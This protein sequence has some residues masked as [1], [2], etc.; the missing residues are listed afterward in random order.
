MTSQEFLAIV[1]PSS[2]YYCACE[3]STS[4]KTH[5]FVETTDEVYNAAMSFSHLGYES[6]YALASF[7]EQGKRTA[8]NT[9]KMRSLFVDIDCG[10]GKDYDN[11]QAAAAAL[12]S[13]LSETTLDSLGTPYILSSG[14]GLHVYWPFQEDLDIDVWKP[15]A[16]N[17]KRLAKL[18]NFNI[19]FGVTADAARIL[20]VPDTNNY[21]KD[22]PRLVK[23]MVEGKTFDFETVKNLIKEKL[24]SSSYEPLV[25]QELDIP[26]VPLQS[27]NNGIKLMEN[28]VNKLTLVEEKCL[29]FQHYKD[30]ASEDG[31]EPL[32]YAMISVAKKCEDGWERMREL[33]EMHPYDDNRLLAKWNQSKGHSPCIKFDS[34]NPGVCINCPKWQKIT[35]PLQLGTEFKTNEEAK[36]LVLLEEDPVHQ[37]TITRP[38]PPKD[39]SYGDKG[40]VFVTKYIED[41]T[42]EK[43][44]KPM[45]LLSYDL[46]VVD[47]LLQEEEHYVHL[48]AV[49]P[50]GNTDIM[51]PQKSVISKDETL[52]N[53][54]SQNVL[55][56][57][58]SLDKDLFYY[59]RGCVEHAS[60]NKVPVKVPASYGWQDD[61]SFVFNSRIY[62]ADGKKTYV[63]MHNLTNINNACKPSGS[64]TEW[65]K[66]YEFLIARQLWE[67]MTLSLVGPASILMEFTGFN[68]VT[69]HTGS[70]KSGTGKT[71]SQAI[72]A[73]W[74]GNPEKYMISAGTSV[75]A[76]Q[77]RQGLFNSLPVIVDE[78]T[79]KQRE[80]LEWLPEYLLA[81]TRGKGKERMESGSNK[82]RINDTSW[83]SIDL[84][85]SNT[86]AHDILTTR[87]HA[88][89]AEMLRILDIEMHEVLALSDEEATILKGMGDHHGVA[90]DKL[91]EWIVAN[92]ETAKAVLKETEEALK[93]EFDCNNDE[94]FWTAGNSCIVAMAVLLGK[95][96]ANIV[97]I[98]IKPLIKVL[99]GMVESGRRAIYGNVRTA[100]DVLN[101]YTRE[102]YGKFVVLEDVEGKLQASLGGQGI[103]DKSITR[104]MV[105]GRVEHNLTPGHIDYFIEEQQLKA[106]CVTMSFVYSEFKRQL[107]TMPTYKIQ[108]MKKDMLTKTRGPSMRVNVMRIT[109]PRVSEAQEQDVS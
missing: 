9:S 65:K 25:R 53:L 59:I 28:S 26:G 35:T 40:G 1:L 7:K 76:I 54:A 12:D 47:L 29:Q 41:D 57:H 61:G 27:T 82:E 101:A 15:V 81:K 20:R 56:A 55:A 103:I 38:V 30:N 52:K 45:M 95:K 22:K 108:Y 86:S 109:V 48:M 92:K 89:R 67:I 106:H 10:V 64:F 36:E 16:E 34:V 91:V 33:S 93:K 13:F 42:G 5:V 75:V 85:S 18:H 24:G 4:N 100:E 66:V 107:E 71:L 8:T 58:G 49:R 62:T 78:T 80:T 73:S 46:F 72:A 31:M 14:G 11:K 32:W 96:Y 84:F 94:R 21:K 99:K 23:I 44:K 17:F 90:G 102:N 63:P 74:W 43:V 88:S 68:G 104:T 50:N 105:A 97:D 51:L 3:V 37:V 79:Q 60:T 19:D 77:H 70:D 2:G 98:P 6:Y 69:Y 39:Y 87:A 83:R